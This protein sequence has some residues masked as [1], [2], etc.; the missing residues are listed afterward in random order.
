M[1]LIR[2]SETNFSEI[3]SEIHYFSSKKMYLQMLSAKWRLFRLGLNVLTV[4]S[5]YPE[6]LLTVLWLSVVC[7]QN[8]V[9]RTLNF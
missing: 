5:Y 7:T 1:L 6:H 3:Q 2:T 4:E 8:A 9:A